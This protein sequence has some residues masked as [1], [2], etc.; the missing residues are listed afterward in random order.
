M[1][2]GRRGLEPRSPGP[3]PGGLARWPTCHRGR[4][5]TSP[6]LPRMTAPTVLIMAAGKGT[7]M[8]SATPKALHDLCGRPLIGW[9]IAAA[10]EAGGAKV[11]VIDGPDRALEG[12]LPDGAE[13]AVQPEAKGTADA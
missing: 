6:T 2:T 9:V 11:V 10:Q 5:G 8:K 1:T 13:I 7:R 12:N 4:K 3:K